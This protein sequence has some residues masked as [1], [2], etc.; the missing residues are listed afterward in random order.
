M[1]SAYEKRSY[2]T[3][4]FRKGIQ[5]EVESLIAKRDSNYEWKYNGSADKYSHTDNTDA[6]MLQ[7]GGR[8]RLCI[9]PCV[10]NDTFSNDGAVVV[11]CCKL[12]ADTNAEMAI[13][14]VKLNGIDQWRKV[15]IDSSFDSLFKSLDDDKRFMGAEWTYGWESFDIDVLRKWITDN[16]IIVKIDYGKEIDILGKYIIGASSRK[17]QEPWIVTMRNKMSPFRS[18]PYIN[19]L[20]NEF[21]SVVPQAT[22]RSV[23]NSLASSYAWNYLGIIV[24][25]VSS[26]EWKTESKE[27]RQKKASDFKLSL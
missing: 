16:D 15:R 18:D 11:A 17:E 6:W 7:N 25:E 4:L 21:L 13:V 5:S 26:D 12:L 19:A 9:R 20:F 22:P 3:D 8:I 24:R 1:N 2:A 23:G 27:Q 10:G 14:L